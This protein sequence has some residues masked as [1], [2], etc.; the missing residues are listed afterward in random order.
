MNQK[1]KAAQILWSSER[2]A[3]PVGGKAPNPE[4]LTISVSHV[5]VGKNPKSGKAYMAY[6]L[7]VSMHPRL[8]EMAGFKNPDYVE[9]GI[10]PES[11]I[12]YFRRSYKGNRL[13]SYKKSS[14][15]LCSFVIWEDWK[16]PERAF[17]GTACRDVEASNGAVAALLPDNLFD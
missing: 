17:P 8:V 1:L 14:R 4:L 10:D 5:R 16:I 2:P 6:R 9:V 3:K 15:S 7:N 12:I 13:S 11:R